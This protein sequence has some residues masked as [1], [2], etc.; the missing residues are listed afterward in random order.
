M[1]LRDETCIPAQGVGPTLTSNEINGFLGELPGWELVDGDH[2][3]KVWTFQDFG[4]ALHWVR[5]AGAICEEQGHHADFQLGWG[6]AAATT[7]THDP[8]GL[9]RSDVVLAAKF[10]AIT[11]GDAHA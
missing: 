5:H 3:H 9:T 11:D 2:L 10:D 8:E 7:Y 4:S 6:Y 1:N